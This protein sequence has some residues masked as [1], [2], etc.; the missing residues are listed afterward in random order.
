ME[1]SF[2]EIFHKQGLIGL[3]MWF[4][5]FT[6]IFRLYLKSLKKKIQDKTNPFFVSALFTFILSFTNPFINNPLGITIVVITIVYFTFLM[7]DNP[8]STI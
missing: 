8:K 6:L 3:T 2:L 7:Y 4:S 5:L 1:I